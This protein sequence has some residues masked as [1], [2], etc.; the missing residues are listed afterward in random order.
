MSLPE[1]S[2]IAAPNSTRITGEVRELVDEV[3][4][5]VEVEV[6]VISE[7]DRSRCGAGASCSVPNSQ[8]AHSMSEFLLAV[9]TAYN[10]GN[11]Q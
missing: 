11:L 8:A 4:V 10:P 7:H 6:V 2:N 5:E 9:L 3:E 1:D